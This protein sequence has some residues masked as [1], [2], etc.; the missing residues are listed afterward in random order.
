MTY[1]TEYKTPVIGTLTL[2]GDDTADA[3]REGAR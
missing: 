2:A 1:C 3:W